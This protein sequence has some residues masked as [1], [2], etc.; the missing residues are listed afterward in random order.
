VPA[1]ASTERAGPGRP[2]TGAR[3]RILAAALEVLKSDGYAG[4]SLAKVAAEAGE[5]KALISYHF[6]SRQGLVSAAAREL[7]EAIT[8][9]ILDGLEDANTVE[10]V[11]RGG[12]D[13]L[14]RLL[15]RDARVA[16]V[17]LDLN[18]VSVVEEEVRAAIR[19]IKAS[20]R[21]ELSRL[22]RRAGVPPRRAGVGAKLLIAG[23]EGFSLDWLERGDT[24]ELR[25]ARAMFTEAITA[26]LTP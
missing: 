3:E 24:P 17:Y 15:E 25:S 10:E 23:N 11:V 19:E 9:E 20:W 2:S 5:N 12:L 4:L 26:Q 22:L 18:A 7:G 1:A 14:W 8:T 21:A 6:G 16:R 13:G